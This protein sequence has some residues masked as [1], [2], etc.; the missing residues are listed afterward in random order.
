MES[1]NIKS[2]LNK[3]WTPQ[4]CGKNGNPEDFISQHDLILSKTLVAEPSDL[5]DQLNDI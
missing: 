3:F 5:L 1:N 2:Y 4:K